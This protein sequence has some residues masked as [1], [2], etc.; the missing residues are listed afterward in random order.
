MQISGKSAIQELV[1]KLGKDIILTT[2]EELIPYMKDASYIKGKMPLAVCLPENADQISSILKIC[3][4]FKIN[5]TAR[6]GG[7]SLPVHIPHTLRIN[8]VQESCLNSWCL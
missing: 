2:K 7:T 6:S 4:K 5:V 3:N 1:D 8:P